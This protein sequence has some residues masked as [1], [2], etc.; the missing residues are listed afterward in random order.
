M[1][2]ENSLPRAE[3]D[4][5]RRRLVVGLVGA[6]LL[7][8]LLVVG[9]SWAKWLP[10]LDKTTSLSDTGAWDGAAIFDTATTAS[11]PW[12]AGWDFTV[13]YFTAVWR[14]L[15]VAVLVAAAV[16][17]LIPRRWLLA[18]LGRRTAVSQSLVGG[19]VSMPS[20]M[21]TCC[22]APVARSLRQRGTP[23]AGCIAYW[24]GNP[25]LNPAVLVFL[26]LVLPWQYAV[27]RLLVGVVVVVGAGVAVSRFLERR[28]VAA[29]VADVDA[30]PDD[31]AGSLR[32]MPGRY[33]RS[34]TRFTVVLVPEYVVA[35]FAVGMVSGPLSNFD[36]ITQQLGVVAVL[37]VAVVATALVVP[38]GGEIPVIAAVTAAGA[39]AGVGGVLLIALPAL[40]LPSMLMVGRSFG[41]RATGLTAGVVVVGSLAAGGMLAVL[42]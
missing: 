14:A 8:A 9:L 11:S 28:Q 37:L 12:A 40:S 16:D 3:T 22:S 42:S 2:A 25:V 23:V 34:L 32:E 6:A 13:A 31:D 38:T 36:G 39:T 10:Y 26:L 1:S 21:C 5:L 18:A 4:D 24:V 29:A 19:I 7:V 41:W 35:V 30:A 33:L 27:V 20:M 17:A 15:V